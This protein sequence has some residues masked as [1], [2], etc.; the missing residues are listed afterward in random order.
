MY[1]DRITGSMER[2]IAETSRRREIQRAYNIEH[3][4]TPEA[5]VKAI[6]VALPSSAQEELTQSAA[7]FKRMS[8]REQVLYLDELRSRMQQA[9]L[10][11]D[12]EQAGHLRD[13]I[14]ELQG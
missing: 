9:A 13:Q 4:I 7:T 1:A 11:L 8:K 12:F 10:N 6:T 5:L 2:A 14:R 3:N